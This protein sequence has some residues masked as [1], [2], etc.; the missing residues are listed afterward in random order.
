MTE[1]VTVSLLWFGTRW[2]ESGRETIRNAI[3][4]LVPSRYNAGDSEVPTLGDWWDI[5][6]QYRDD[7]NA[8]VTDRV[9]V[10]A[11]CFY[12][13]SEL[14]MT[15]DRV[16]EIGK[17][18]FNK[19]AVE[20]SGGRLNC[21]RVFDVD[22]NRIYHILFSYSVMFFEG[23][24]QREFTDWCSGKFQL[25]GMMVSMTWAREPQIA[26]DQCSI[27]FRRSSYLGPPN[28]DEKIDSLVG[29]MVAKI[30][31]EVTDQDGRGWIS[32]D[33]TGLT[34]SSSCI[35]PFGEAK[36]LPPPL[37]VD[38]ERRFSFNAVGLNGYRYIVPYIWDQNIRNCALKPSETCSRNAV[39][40]EQAS[41]RLKGGIVVNHT[42]GL[43]PYPP[44]QKCQ[45]EINFPDAKFISFTVNFL[46]IS[47]D[48]DD[49]LRICQPNSNPVQCSTIQSNNGDFDKN[50]KV[51]GSK[52]SI[53]FS[54]GDHVAFKSRGWELSYTA[55][56]CNGKKDVYDP[57]GTI[58]NA[59]SSYV[60]G[61]TCQWILHGKPGTPVNL[62]FIHINITKNLDF[63]AINNGTKQQI[64]NFSGSY[65]ESDLP[66]MNLTG[67][68]TIIFATQTDEGQG[69]SAK[70]HISSPVDRN[71][72]VWLVIVIVVL[73]IISAIVSLSFVALA[74]LKRRRMHKTSLDSVEELMQV[75]VD[76]N[77]ELN[78]IGEGPSAIVYRA[79]STNGNTVAV[80]SRRDSSSDTGL[81]EEI[82]LKSSF[83]PHIVSLLGYAQAQNGL[84]QRCLVFEFMQ[85]GSLRWNLRED[86]GNL[87]WEK[88]LEI[89]LQICSA[90]QMLHMYSKPPI[91]HGNIT[92]E[93]ILLDEF[94]NAKLSGFGAA[95]YF[96]STR[97]P[98]E[99]SEMAEDI[100]SF[101]LL[102]VELLQGEPVVNR[103]GCRNFSRLEQIN[104]LVGGGIE[105]LDQ[106]LAIPEENWKVMGL[107]KL[108]E[109]AKWCIGS[110]C[111]IEG[112]ENDAKI[113]DVLSGLR[114]VKQL[115]CSV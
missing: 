18:V 74:I 91:F 33:G 105:F 12:S 107:A 19:T 98:E 95:S 24:Q 63:L 78:R 86:G 31:E 32:N 104:D 44:N 47:A 9:S 49:R 40:L 87:D 96:S 2:E 62:S 34:I 29:H 11:E 97:N 112:N 90:I 113:G 69:W 16:V 111:R 43:Q 109:I 30:A 81:E 55:G 48:S 99:T 83:H 13:G 37:Y 22:E 45:W 58:G 27:S 66:K 20:G 51:F 100:C 53:E 115:F 59:S 5:V 60:K 79:V 85:R 28:G 80:K 102:L 65:S 6:R 46:A 61:L 54:S 92:S 57:D 89:V 56:M 1:P 35:S 3:A 42:D 39:V 88:R 50:F 77:R 68:V 21:T 4:S 84:R 52:A 73:A 76:I 15:L 72:K 67:E 26:A 94:Y 25:P 103:Q 64:A 14:N 108:G 41:G 70:F 106:R 75:R 82:L 7:S 8:Q 23:Q 93:N 101:G 110:C 38:E 114:Q 10:G 71:K 36:T 17:S